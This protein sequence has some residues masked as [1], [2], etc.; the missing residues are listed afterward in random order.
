MLT[1]KMQIP[2][3]LL[4]AHAFVNFLAVRD[5]KHLKFKVRK[6]ESHLVFTV[7]LYR[8]FQHIK[9]KFVMFNAHIY[10]QNALTSLEKEV[11]ILSWKTTVRFLYEP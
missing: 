9:S 4:I 6:F 10:E 3:T 5:T 7:E 1:W 8:K 2:I 11:I